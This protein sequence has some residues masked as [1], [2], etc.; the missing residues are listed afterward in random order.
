MEE[1]FDDHGAVDVRFVEE[2][3]VVG[4]YGVADEQGAACRVDRLLRVG[5]RVLVGAAVCVVVARE[6]VEGADLL[7]SCAHFVV[8]V[9]EK[10][11]DVSA[12]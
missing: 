10:A 9:V 1:A 12:W 6:W 2:R 3:V 8:A 5:G 7:P 11:A 4:Q